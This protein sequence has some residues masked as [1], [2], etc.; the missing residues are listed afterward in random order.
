M[1]SSYQYIS[2]ISLRFSSSF[3]Q[4]ILILIICL[5]KQLETAKTKLY[6][7]SFFVKYTTDQLTNYVHESRKHPYIGCIPNYIKINREK[8][9]HVSISTPIFLK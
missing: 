7:H 5:T 9:N 4:N 1:H 6:M 2:K 3:Q 8:K